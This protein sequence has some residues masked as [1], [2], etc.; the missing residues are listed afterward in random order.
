ML[1]HQI[2]NSNNININVDDLDD[3][4]CLSLM[5]LV[6][7]ISFK[8]MF[9]NETIINYKPH[10]IHRIR[11]SVHAII[12]ELGKKFKNYYWMRDLSF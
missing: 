5:R 10:V 7:M 2:N 4:M 6:M 11:S 1:Q 3:P 8:L 12:I 9:I